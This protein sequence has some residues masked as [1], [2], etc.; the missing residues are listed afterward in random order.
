ML[1]VKHRQVT[2]LDVTDF[3]GP[4]F[5]SAQRVLCGDAS[6]LFLDHFSKHLSSVLGWTELCR[7]VWNPGPQKAQIICNENHY[8]AL[9]EICQKM[10]L[11]ITKHRKRHKTCC[12]AYYNL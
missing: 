10:S 1:I 11:T 3:W 8:L 12:N 9:L 7:E 4:G 2:D 5:R 6:R